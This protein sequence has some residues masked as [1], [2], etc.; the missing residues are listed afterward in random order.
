MRA[1]NGSATTP[2]FSFS[3]DTNTGMYSGGTDI[4]KFATA[5]ADR[6]TILADG[7]MGIGTTSP[8]KA[9][10]VAG[11]IRLRGDA[12]TLNFYRNT[13]PTDIAYIKYDEVGASFDIATDNRN[14]RFLN[15][16]TWGESMRITSTGSV[17]IGTPSPVSLFSVGATLSS[18]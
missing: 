17:G 1:A 15:K 8:G 12:A 14:I 18:R 5:G 13:S 3:A 2:A 10:D 6:V 4:L 16:V 7:K 11:D 9:L